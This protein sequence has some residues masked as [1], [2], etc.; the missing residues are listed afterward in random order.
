VV[1]ESDQIDEPAGQHI[2]GQPLSELMAR[3][4]VGS[5]GGGRRRRRDE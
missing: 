1:D 4:Q 3:L 2:G 5:T